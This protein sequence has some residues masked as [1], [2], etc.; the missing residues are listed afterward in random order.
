MG[1]KLCKNSVGVARQVD[2]PLRQTIHIVRRQRDVDAV[3]HVEPLGVVVALFRHDGDLRHEGKSLREIGKH[4]FTGDGIALRVVLPTW[5][6]C[7]QR[8]SGRGV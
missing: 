5:K 7:E 3:V 4:E 8:S 1:A 6:R 2:I